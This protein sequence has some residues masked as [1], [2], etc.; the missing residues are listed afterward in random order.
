VSFLKQGAE[1]ELGG[2]GDPR[3]A[4]CLLIRR[5]LCGVCADCADCSGF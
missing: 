3:V 4:G 2:G 1:E 5:T